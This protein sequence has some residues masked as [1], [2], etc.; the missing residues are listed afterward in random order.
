MAEVRIPSDL[1]DDDRQAVI[2]SW[3]YADGATVAAGDGIA[4][5]MVEKAQMEINAP[6]SGV[7]H[8]L[9]QEETLV[10]RGAVIATID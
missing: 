3:A 9:K 6:A 8:I 7:L 1:W 4:E 10:G 2:T 5:I